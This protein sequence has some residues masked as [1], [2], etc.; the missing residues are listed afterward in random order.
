VHCPDLAGGCAVTLA[1]RPVQ[2]RFSAPPSALRPFDVRVDALSA[3]RVSANFRMVGMDMGRN[4]YQLVRES[5]GR[6]L[7]HV[8]LPVCVAGRSDWVMTLIV[9]GGAVDIPFTA[10]K[11]Y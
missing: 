1:G 4:R 8:I 3:A 2:V 5:G 6:W 11:P 9:D 7:A 10:V